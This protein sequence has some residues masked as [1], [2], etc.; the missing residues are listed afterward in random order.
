MNRTCFD[1]DPKCSVPSVPREAAVELALRKRVKALG[2]W[3]L[4]LVCPGTAGVPDR[5]VLGPG[6]Q[7]VFVELKRPGERPRPLQVRRHE[8]LRVLG[9]R[10]EVIDS[11]GGAN[12]F[13]F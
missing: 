5:L 1:F 9:F 13:S 4:K 6:G 11:V 2:G 3:A 10:V 12:A 8:Q 7:V